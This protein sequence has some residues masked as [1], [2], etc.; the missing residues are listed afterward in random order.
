M[1][2]I[3]VSAQFIMCC[4]SFQALEDLADFD[5]TFSDMLKQYNKSKDIAKGLKK[6]GAIFS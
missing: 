4:F 6:V 1:K 2:C 3:E 5:R